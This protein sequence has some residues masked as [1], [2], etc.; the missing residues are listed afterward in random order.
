M[1]EALLPFCKELTPRHRDLI[2]AVM[3]AHAD[4]AGANTPASTTAAIIQ[5]QIGGT[6]ESAMIAAINTIGSKHAP[7]SKCRAFWFYDLQAMNHSDWKAALQDRLMDNMRIPGF[8]HAI[9][10]GT[11]APELEQVKKALALFPEGERFIQEATAAVNER[12]PDL[13]PN[14]ALYTALAL[15][16]IELRYGLE[17]MIFVLSRLPIWAMAW[18]NN[19]K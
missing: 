5:G 14:I 7:V 19:L 1:I 10:K 6:F 18:G 9:Y 17:S 16:L 13:R 15:E 12:R 8:G 3:Q 4:A 11:D 2:H